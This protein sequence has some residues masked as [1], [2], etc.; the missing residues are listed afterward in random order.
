MGRRWNALPDGLT[1]LELGMGRF[2]GPLGLASLYITISGI[3]HFLA[4]LLS[5]FAA[6]G[7]MLV[8][9][10]L[11][12]ILLGMGMRQGIRWVPWV[13]FVMM[14]VFGS[15][16]LT[17][18]YDPTSAVP[19]WITFAIVAFD[20]VTAFFLLVHLWRDPPAAPS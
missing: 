17:M 3:C 8:P 12:Y 19:S 2:N 10:G 13:S 1:G 16:A 5:G 20:W 15:A 11:V 14:L 7:L 9:F 18:A 6:E 4:A